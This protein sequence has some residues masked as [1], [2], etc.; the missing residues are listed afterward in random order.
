M[1]KPK[2]YVACNILLPLC[3]HRCRASGRI[4]LDWE[5]DDLWAAA[6]ILVRPLSVS[7]RVYSTRTIVSVRYSQYKL[8]GCFSFGVWSALSP[9]LGYD[10]VVFQIK[11]CISKSNCRRCIRFMSSERKTLKVFFFRTRLT[12]IRRHIFATI[13]GI[14][15]DVN[16]Q[17]WTNRLAS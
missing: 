7:V 9:W 14:T 2:L 12:R 1:Y 4:N 15:W 11:M 17:R 5:R 6:V 16:W 3:A 8:L 10:S 13:L